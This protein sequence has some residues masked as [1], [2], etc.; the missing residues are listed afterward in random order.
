VQT[1]GDK[2]HD[3]PVLL[4]FA[5]LQITSGIFLEFFCG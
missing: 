1:E 4:K 5:F 2:L 3:P